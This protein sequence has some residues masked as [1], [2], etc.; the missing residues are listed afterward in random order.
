MDYMDGFELDVQVKES[1]AENNPL[2][3]SLIGCTP[4][5]GETGSFNSFCC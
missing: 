5:C 2:I 3:T 4:G 1:K